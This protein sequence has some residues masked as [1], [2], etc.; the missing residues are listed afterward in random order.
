MIKSMAI[1]QSDFA[2]EQATK[3]QNTNKRKIKQHNMATRKKN[4]NQCIKLD[5]QIDTD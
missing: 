2:Y 5:S 1:E 4:L 3:K